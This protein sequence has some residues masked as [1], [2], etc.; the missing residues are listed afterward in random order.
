MSNPAQLAL[1]IVNKLL[2]QKSFIADELRA[3]YDEEAKERQSEAGKKFKPSEDKKEDV[4]NLSQVTPEAP[5]AR[6]KVGKI[7]GV[8]GAYVDMAIL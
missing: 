5:K 3:H 2:A 4:V 7:L 1:N 6:D 8:S